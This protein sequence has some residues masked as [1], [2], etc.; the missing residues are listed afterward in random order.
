MNSI[1]HKTSRAF[2][3]L[4]I[5]IVFICL[6]A[7]FNLLYLQQQVKEGVVIANFKDDI[8]EMRRHEKNLFL[9]HNKN[10]LESILL[11]TQKAIDNLNTNQQTYQTLQPEINLLSYKKIKNL[12]KPA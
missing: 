3:L 11:F 7:F 6:F 10:E 1:R 5:F 4:A 9:Y 2:Y 12:S 8:L